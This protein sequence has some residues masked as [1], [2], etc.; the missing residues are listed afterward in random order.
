MGVQCFVLQMDV[1]IKAKDD[2]G[3]IIRPVVKPATIRIIL[4]IVIRNDSELRQLDVSNVFLH[5]I[6]EETV[7]ISQPPGFRDSNKLDHVCRLLKSIYRLKQ[8]PRAWFRWLCDY[9]V[10]LGFKEGI[11]DQSLFVFKNEMHVFLVEIHHIN[12]WEPK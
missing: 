1:Q 12:N 5:G 8:S 11:S 7:F 4:S 6:F 10:T 9:L 3:R 2:N